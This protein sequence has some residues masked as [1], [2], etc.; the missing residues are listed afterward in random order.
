[1]NLNIIAV[2]GGKGG[3]GKS[4]VCA[5]LAVGLALSGRRVV[6]AD[7]DFGASNLHALLGISNPVFGFQD[8][9]SRTSEDP[10]ALLLETGIENLKFLSGA[11]DDPGSAN[12][13]REKIAFL[14]SFI[15]KL[16]A[17]TILIDLGPGTSYNGIDLFN[18]CDTA[19][20]LTTPE[21]TSVTNTFSFIRSALFR[22]FGKVFAGRPELLALVDNSEPAGANTETSTLEMLK[23]KLH[24]ID[25]GQEGVID[26]ILASFHPKL[27]VNRVRTKKDLRA[28]ENLV[29]LVNKYLGVDLHYLGYIIESDRVRDSV[30]SMTPFLIED[31]QSKPSENIQQIL[32]ALIDADLKL[33]KRDGQIFISKQV[34]LGSP[35]QN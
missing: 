8:I 1:M 4:I 23:E 21:I 30:D 31:P 3:I 13:D 29:R 5:N 11:G 20:V 25:P 2:G 9:F 24:E 17:D 33:I 15:K 12:I 18:L 34:R 35:W 28:G 6:L 26:S 32:G 10:N 22:R 7:A 16:S 19:L 27:I 14:F